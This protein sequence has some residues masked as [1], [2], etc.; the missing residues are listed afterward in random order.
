M[1]K[2]SEIQMQTIFGDGTGQEGGVFDTLISAGKRMLTG[3][4]LFLTA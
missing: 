4:S 1:M 2:S 3:E